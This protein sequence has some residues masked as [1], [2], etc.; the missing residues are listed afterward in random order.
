[1]MTALHAVTRSREMSCEAFSFSQFI[2]AA[3]RKREIWT[4][5]KTAVRAKQ[6]LFQ[7][8][9][10][11]NYCAALTCVL[12]LAPHRSHVFSCGGGF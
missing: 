10:S 8:A 9:Q 12:V 4:G 1:M 11:D 7:E 6:N 5:D 2:T 3:A